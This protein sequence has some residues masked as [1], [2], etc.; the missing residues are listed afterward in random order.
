MCTTCQVAERSYTCKVCGLLKG[1]ASFVDEL[2]RHFLDHEGRSL[3]S[4]TC[5][6]KGF[7]PTY[8]TECSCVGCRK[9]RCHLTF[10]RDDL[11][12]HKHFG[13]QLLCVGCKDKRAKT[14]KKMKEKGAWACK[15]GAED[16]SLVHKGKCPLHPARA[17]ERRWP[18]KHEHV[19]ERIL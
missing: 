11:K 2:L 13:R 4:V 14:A 3:I 12:N 6:D 19:D 17:G 16:R 1:K 8:C 18:G 10:D 15:C 7:S 9:E 5:Q